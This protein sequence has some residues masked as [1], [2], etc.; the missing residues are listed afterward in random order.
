[1][2]APASGCPTPGSPRSRD[3]AP[4]SGLLDCLE[5][6]NPSGRPPRGPHTLL[7]S[8]RRCLSE[9]LPRGVRWAAGRRV[10]A[11]AACL[12][13]RPLERASMLLSRCTSDTASPACSRVSISSLSRCSFVLDAGSLDT[14]CLTGRAARAQLLGS[15]SCWTRY[16][17]SRF[18]AAGAAAGPDERDLGGDG[19]RGLRRTL[20]VL[21][22]CR[23]GPFGSWPRVASEFDPLYVSHTRATS[24][25]NAS[26]RTAP[27]EASRGA[28]VGR[29][30]GARPAARLE[31]EDGSPR[32]TTFLRLR[33]RTYEM[34]SRARRRR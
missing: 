22:N 25:S 16:S 12:N 9:G 23:T 31:M 20:V 15:S 17:S 27:P 3:R 4:C 21:M 30:R 33:G 19:E 18:S 2:E 11:A 6:R 8:E 28:V 1:M 32:R 26:P 10:H 14:V 5:V 34:M 13:G 24:G 29:R 7:S